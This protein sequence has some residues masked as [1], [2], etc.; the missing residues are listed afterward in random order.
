M[1]LPDRN[2]WHIMSHPVCIV[3]SDPSQFVLSTKIPGSIKMMVQEYT[4]C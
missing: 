2:W 1:A 3:Y 4:F